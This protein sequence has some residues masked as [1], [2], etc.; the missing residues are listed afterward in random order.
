MIRNKIFVW[1]VTLVIALGCFSNL[2]GQPTNTLYFLDMLP[3]SNQMNPANLPACRTHVGMPGVSSIMIN[4][5][6]N[7]ANLYD[8]MQ[9]KNDSLY[10]FWT[11]G[12]D[13]SEF[14]NAF[15]DYNYTGI[16]TTVDLLSFGFYTGSDI[17]YGFSIRERVSG[18]FFYTQDLPTLIY[19]NVPGEVLD[20]NGFGFNI[21]WFRE[22]ALTVGKNLGGPWTIG[23]RGKLLFGK[24]NL[25]TEN[26]KLQVRTDITEWHP[27]SDVVY[28]MALPIIEPKYD[29]NGDVEKFKE[30]AKYDE[31]D[32]LFYSKNWGLAFDM[33]AKFEPSDELALSASVIDLGFIRWG[34]DAYSYTQK[35]D[36]YYRGA[37]WPSDTANEGIG[38]YLTDVS[39]RYV[40]SANFVPDEEPYTKMLSGKIYIGG[41]YNLTDYFYL[42]L[43]SRTLIQNHHV[44]ENVMF[45]TNVN[46]SNILTTSLSYSA[47][48]RSYNN[49]GFGLGVRAAFF[50]LYLLSDNAVSAAI[51]PQYTKSF[52]FRFGLNLLFGC[53]PQIDMPSIY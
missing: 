6:N 34:N 40:D 7:G 14:V 51:W 27:E 43:L 42:G 48:H 29:E 26:N 11:E 46:L 18:N 30:K 52:N 41:R 53:R 35:G 15:G 16:E 49:I 45:S 5:P 19:G 39:E 22:Y 47:M 37:A 21:S 24:A 31:M 25:F 2:Y 4:V 33:G 17:Y 50:N 9:Y 1:F 13:S 32:M 12:G 28:H 3:Q 38:G 36:F 8:I 44:H 20:F 23:G 10:P